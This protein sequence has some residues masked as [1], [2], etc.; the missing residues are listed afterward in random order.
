[1]ARFIFIF[2]LSLNIYAI[3]IGK[4]PF[5]VSI[6]GKDGGYVKDSSVWSLEDLRGFVNIIFYVDPD[7]KDKNEHFAQFLKSKKYNKDK[8]FKSWAIINMAA[9][10][11]PNF[12]IEK[13][14]KSKQE[15]YKTTNYVK[16]KNS[17]L[18]KKWGL[19]DDDSD[20]IIIDKDLNVRFVKFG[21]MGEEDM[22]KAAEI[23]EE[24]LGW[25]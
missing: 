6:S 14:L 21:K 4:K 22:K 23:I 25:R 1:M 20:I 17:V 13:I 2:F 3:E 8:Q 5:D 7:E 11:K 12:I 24:E 18:V 10:W 16:D 19:K 15:E 9:T